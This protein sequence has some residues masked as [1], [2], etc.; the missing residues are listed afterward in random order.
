MKTVP[1]KPVMI[2]DRNALVHSVVKNTHDFGATDY[3]YTVVHGEGAR[4]TRPSHWE[5]PNAKIEGLRGEK[6]GA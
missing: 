6:F 4:G 5:G 2:V 3:A 1:M